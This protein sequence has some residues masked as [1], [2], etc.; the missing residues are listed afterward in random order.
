MEEASILHYK[1]P[2]LTANPHYST[3]VQLCLVHLKIHKRLELCL[4]NNPLKINSFH[5]KCL[6]TSAGPD[7]HLNPKVNST[8]K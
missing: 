5:L 4:I 2:P 6:S 3:A 1:I 7:Y 8:C